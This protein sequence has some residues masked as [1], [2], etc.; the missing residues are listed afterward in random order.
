MIGVEFHFPSADTIY[1]KFVFRV[2]GEAA[3]PASDLSKGSSPA[4]RSLR[5]VR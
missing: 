1:D 4:S 2:N 3:P 5:W